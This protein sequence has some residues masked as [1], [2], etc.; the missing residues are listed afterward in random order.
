M[1][2]GTQRDHYANVGEMQTYSGTAPVTQSSG[3][4]RWV[5]VRWAC[6]TFLRQTFHEFAACSI[7]RSEWARIFYD[8]KIA[9][10]KS[11]H[12]A[13]RALG[14][15]VDSRAVPLL[16]RWP[17]L[18]RTDLLTGVGPAER[19]VKIDSRII[20]QASVEDRRRFYQTIHRKFL[21]E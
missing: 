10:G 11:H 5:H 21:T 18:R 16:E 2:F 8:A 15:Q 3:H 7:S 14:V 9:A 20:E 4:T 19:T 12:A 13:V 1:A 6:P 17:P